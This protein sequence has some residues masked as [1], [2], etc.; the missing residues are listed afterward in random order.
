MIKIEGWP[1]H[2]EGPATRLAVVRVAS[3][4]RPDL[5]DAAKQNA[6][7][8][9]LNPPTTTTQPQRQRSRNDNEAAT[10]TKPQRQRSHNVAKTQ[11]QRSRNAAATTKVWRG[12][13]RGRAVESADRAGVRGETRRCMS[14]R[15]QRAS[16]HRRP[17]NARR[18]G[19][20]K[21]ANVCPPHARLVPPPASPRPLQLTPHAHP[22]S[23][24]RPARATRHPTRTRQ[25][26]PSAPGTSHDERD[27]Y[28]PMSRQK[29]HP[30]HARRHPA[31]TP[32]A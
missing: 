3:R 11:P 26:P 25:A 21:A 28:H 16:L 8:R 22:I 10:T 14:E 30:P 19:K 15:A 9:L 5:S 20:P 29:H 12:R 17:A 31:P 2:P 4:H 23:R 13:G 6:A 27:P 32:S 24:R 7:Q 1:D 18:I